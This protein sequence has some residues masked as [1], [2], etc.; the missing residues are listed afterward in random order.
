MR[1]LQDCCFVHL[2]VG[3][4]KE[5]YDILP[6]MYNIYFLNAGGGRDRKGV[7]KGSPFKG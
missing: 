6:F 2:V 1:L 7:K 5:Q 4:E 3:L